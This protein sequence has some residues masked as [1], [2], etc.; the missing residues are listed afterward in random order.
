[1]VLIL[2]RHASATGQEPDA[3]L[4]R[5]GDIQAEL[6]ASFINDFYSVDRIISSPFKRAL[7]TAEPLAKH[8]GMDIEV[9][10]RL[11]ERILCDESSDNDY[12]PELK[13]SFLNFDHRVNANSESNAEALIRVNEFLQNLSSQSNKDKITVAISHGNL[14]SLILGKFIPFGFDECLALS[15]PDVFVI[16]VAVGKV[17]RIWQTSPS[18]PRII[19]RPST[20][21]ILL[22]KDCS[23]VFMFLLNDPNVSYNKLAPIPKWITPG[24]GMEE[25]DTEK[26]TALK[27]ELWEELSLNENAYEIIGHLWSS[28]KKACLWKNIPY[29]FIDHYFVVRM[30]E[31]FEFSFVNQTKEE[32][33]VLTRG[34]WWDLQS[35][36]ET[37]EIIIPVQLRDFTFSQNDFMIPSEPIIIKEYY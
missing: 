26:S 34:R 11:R 33:A 9:D 3:P 36:R 25:F 16:D 15:N 6:L 17:Q 2:I 24:G 7:Q 29:N 35:L 5:T 10:S 13:Q 4:T 19:D 20:R 23:K 37:N 18:L 28:E 8:S 30:T 31:D 1:M 21:A 14:C 22:N 32:K 12:L 27:R